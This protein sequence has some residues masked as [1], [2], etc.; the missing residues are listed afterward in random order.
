[1]FRKVHFEALGN[2]YCSPNIIRVIK[3]RRMRWAVHTVHMGEK[4]IACRILEGN[5]LGKERR[6]KFEVSIRMDFREI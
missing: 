4:R 3:S 1:M 5:L 6:C 2:L